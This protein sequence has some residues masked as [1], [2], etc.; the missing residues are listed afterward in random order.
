MCGNLKLCDAKLSLLPLL[1]EIQA[2][3]FAVILRSSM[4]AK[5]LVVE[6][7]TL[8]IVQA[9]NKSDREILKFSSLQNNL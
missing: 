4:G 5:M 3:I 1:A 6:F 9:N 7:P 8:A 2:Y